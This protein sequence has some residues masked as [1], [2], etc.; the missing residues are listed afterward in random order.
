MH[1]REG[2]QKGRG[3]L[4]TF[5]LDLTK[6]TSEEKKEVHFSAARN[7]RGGGQKGEEKMLAST[8]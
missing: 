8:T 3:E 6:K 7:P 5:V 4:A 2:R 1:E